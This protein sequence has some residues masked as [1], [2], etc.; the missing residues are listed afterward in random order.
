MFVAVLSKRS[1][2]QVAKGKE[3]RGVTPSQRVHPMNSF[4]DITRGKS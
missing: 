4:A 3:I 2:T 1:L